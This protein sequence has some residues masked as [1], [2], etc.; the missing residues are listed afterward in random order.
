MLKK[1]ICILMCAVMLNVGAVTAEEEVQDNAAFDARVEKLA[2]LGVTFDEGI[3][4]DT[5]VTRAKFIRTLLDFVNAES[6]NTDCGFLDVDKDHPYS[7]EINTGAN[8][9]YMIGYPDGY[10][11]PDNIITVNDSIKAIVNSLGYEVLAKQNGGYPLGYISIGDQIELLDG[12]ASGTMGLTYDTFSKL[13]ENALECSIYEMTFEEGTPSYGENEDVDALWEFH[14]IIKVKAVVTAN[15]VTG[16]EEAQGKT[17][18]NEYVE[19]NGE[20]V[21]AGNSEAAK[22]LGYSVE[23]YVY[24][25]DKDE[26]GEIKFIEPAKKN[27]TV[28]VKPENIL[29]DTNEFSAY[30][31]VY[32]TESGK[33]KKAEITEET[34]I[35]YNGVAKPDYKEEDL[36][37]KIGEVTLID[38]D[39]DSDIDCISIFKA[40]KV[41]IVDYVSSKEE[42]MT[43]VD[44]K[45]SSN[46]YF[47]D[48]EYEDYV[49][50]VN[51]EENI[52]S[53]ILKDMVILIGTNG[54]HSITYAFSNIV[55]GKIDSMGTADDGATGTVTV[56]G[57]EYK[58]APGA[59]NYNFS[60]GAV[61]KLWV[62]E[63]FNVYGFEKTET[64]GKVYGYFIRGYYDE[65]E[66]YSG[67]KVLTEENKIVKI[68]FEDHVK[69]NGS[70]K[71]VKDMVNFLKVKETDDADWKPQLI[72]YSL[73]ENGKVNAI[74]TVENDE[75]AELTQAGTYYHCAKASLPDEYQAVATAAGL[76]SGP[77]WL[78]AENNVYW[79]PTHAYA[80][81]YNSWSNVWYNDSNT[82]WFV[83]N[84]AEPEK[85]YVMTGWEVPT[86]SYDYVHELYNES[87]ETSTIGAIVW[88]KEGG[89]AALPQIGNS[90]RA[91]IVK[92]VS[93]GLNED[94]EPV[95]TL[96]CV[97]AG[98][99]V[100]IMW[101]EDADQQVKDVFNSLNP[102][103]IIYYTLDSFG[104]VDN[105]YRSFNVERV[106]EYGEKATESSE[107]HDGK[108]NAVHIEKRCTY[109]QIKRKLQNNFY[110]YTGN[111]DDRLGRI[112]KMYGG[113]G[114][115]RMTVRGKK[116]TVETITY[117]DV[118]AGD[119]I[120][121]LI[122]GR[123]VRDMIVIDVK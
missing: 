75:D 72:M 28:T 85:S 105:M 123:T 40:E 17:S 109:V 3:T 114:V 51:G 77:L 30:N 57:V 36:I 12:V 25:E 66:D 4:A 56:G 108:T 47:Y 35:I 95:K 88:R 92:T 63:D 14:N 50:Y 8:L 59:E 16:L 43:V 5:T 122:T 112:Q 2:Y 121:C 34:Y 115:Y 81:Y 110:E 46:T 93:S 102:G 60:L 6:Y 62:D 27:V 7:E 64:D 31:F 21:Y 71:E 26:T 69:Y 100:T 86:I 99:T 54:E 120:Y 11:Y 42:G 70:R 89:Q 79:G 94:D 76:T 19:L 61:G 32:E 78:D 90:N 55:E 52:Q 58:K 22:Y 73:S 80:Y 101:N 82:V 33:I 13:L 45:D 67:I 20:K 111:D 98:K 119:D 1:L 91:A 117:D 113:G 44:K 103:D 74:N 39:S 9:G 24:Y 29:Y 37:P 84:D 48:A 10:Y 107:V 118:M 41:M 38:N 49:V 87:E 65:D 106:G 15:S 53:S 104:K 83:A 97:Q 18:G 96:E 23:A 116:V 68:E